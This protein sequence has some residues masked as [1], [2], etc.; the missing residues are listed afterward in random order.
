V[1]VALKCAL[2][3]PHFESIHPFEDGNGRVGRALVAKTLA[4]GLG[5]ALVLPVSTVLD[6]YRK[7]YYEAIHEASQS[8][9]WTDWAKF[10]IPVLSETLSGFLSAAR[11]ISA[12]GAYLSMY[13]G[14]ISERAKAVILRMFRDGPA[15]V[16]A[17]LSAAKWMRM[18]KVS[19]PT[20]TR[21]LAELAKTGAILA[22]GNGAQ[23]RYRLAFDLD[24]H[25][26][27]DEPLNEPLNEPK[28]EGINEGT[29]RDVHAL[30][31]KSPGTRV[32]FIVEALGVSRA[33]VKRALAA[34]IAAGKVE[35]RGSKKAG[36]YFCI[37]RLRDGSVRPPTSYFP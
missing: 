11:F 7:D 5:K 25:E 22:E 35:H 4:E 16:A 19:K 15:G 20:A 6:R 32:P 3:H 10:F 9:D 33:T 13:E 26:P 18:T 1:D 29:K 14:R 30:V 21:D 31:R 12:K 36:G 27:I 17:G 23:T 37:P 34:L 2:L 24:S 8:L 28:D